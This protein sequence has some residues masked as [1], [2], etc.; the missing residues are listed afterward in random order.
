MAVGVT[1]F[2]DVHA[3]PGKGLKAP[4]LHGHL[5]TWKQPGRMRVPGL[6]IY[7]RRRL[8]TAA[9][10]AAPARRAQTTAK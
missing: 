6:T 2:V 8:A 1:V 3:G 10:N 9:P 5:S 7:M 4:K